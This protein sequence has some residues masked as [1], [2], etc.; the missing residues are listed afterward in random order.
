MNKKLKIGL[1]VIVCLTTI[2]LIA[3]AIIEPSIF[4]INVGKNKIEKSDG[5]SKIEKIYGYGERVSYGNNVNYGYLEKI[6]YCNNN[7]KYEEKVLC[8]DGET[9]YYLTNNIK[10]VDVK[11]VFNIDDENLILNFKPM[12]LEII[13]KDDIKITKSNITRD[14]ITE[15]YYKIG[16][17]EDSHYENASIYMLILGFDTHFYRCDKEHYKKYYFINYNNEN[18]VLSKDSDNLWL[19][20]NKCG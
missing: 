15:K 14:G 6:L 17:I 20:V 8:E 13:E 4:G 3:I 2:Q 7:Y 5:V 16:T 18:L 11:S 1:I 12:P 9:K 10:I 19:Y